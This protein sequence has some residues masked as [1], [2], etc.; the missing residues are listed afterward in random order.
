MKAQQVFCQVFQPRLISPVSRCPRLNPA[1][2]R[3]QRIQNCELPAGVG[4]GN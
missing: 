3:R 1:G 4:R 2:A